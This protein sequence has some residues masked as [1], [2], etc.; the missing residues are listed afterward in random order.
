[1]LQNMLESIAGVREAV[2]RHVARNSIDADKRSLQLPT[3]FVDSQV[4]D[5][6]RMLP[7]L[8]W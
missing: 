4:G 2:G 3:C 7:N 5:L 8:E 1:M 6:G